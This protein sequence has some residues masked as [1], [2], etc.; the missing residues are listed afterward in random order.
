MLAA[1]P[2]GPMAQ[3]LGE[4]AQRAAEQRQSTQVPSRS[5]STGD[6]KDESGARLDG[7][8]PS[9]F[10]NGARP[11]AGANG[12]PPTREDI[13]RAVMPAV[14]TIESSAGVGSGFFVDQGVVLTN[15]HVVE[16]GGLLKI[17]LASGETTTGSV[18]QTATDADVAI[19]HV[20]R[21]TPGQPLLA[22]GSAVDLR[23][24]GEVL[25]VGS[26]LG[27]LRSTVTR[28]IVSAV[29]TIGGLTYVQTDAAINPGNSGG[30]LVDDRG[31]VIGITTAKFKAG[32]SLGLAL[33]IDHG[34][35]LVEGRGPSVAW[36][37]A[38]P[39]RGLDL[40]AVDGSPRRNDSDDV[41]DRGAREFEGVMQTLARHAD[42][43]DATWQRSRSDCG[44]DTRAAAGSRAWFG[45]LADRG[46]AD[47]ATGDCHAWLSNIAEDAQSIDGE[48]RRANAAARQAGVYPGTTRDL[49]RKYK[50]DWSGWDR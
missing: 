4:A 37:P 36:G 5:F 39:G 23:V 7:R 35:R 2:S 9:R 19:V 29:R 40:A 45:L 13:V 8:T 26:P 12:G 1:A 6:L 34:V 28:G 20:D 25:A 3:S 43:L 18:R 24:G 48:V 10:S 32:E 27:V 30:P 14:V 46:L 41:R 50:L 47:R 16:G 49:R 15:R 17:R 38:T 44:P 22:L 11:P 21:P 42:R 33:G 31:Y